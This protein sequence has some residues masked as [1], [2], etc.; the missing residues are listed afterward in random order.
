MTG[1]DVRAAPPARQVAAGDL[2]FDVREWGPADGRLV[3]A[4]HGFPQ[5]GRVWT[6]LGS[7]LAADGVRLVAPDIRGYSPGARPADV[8]AYRQSVVGDDVPALVAA[9]GADRADVV[10]HDWGAAQAWQAA[11]RHPGAVRS[12]VA[13]SVPHPLAVLDALADPDQRGRA[14]YIRWFRRTPDAAR[15][16]L[17]DDAAV[18]REFYADGAGVDVDAWVEPLRDVERLDA[19]LQWY[20][21][22][23]PDAVVGLGDVVCPTVHVWSDGDRALGRTGAEATARHVAGPYRFV[24]LPGGS[25]WIPEEAPDVV[26]REVRAQLAAVPA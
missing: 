24:E 2:V 12:L 7:A 25:H 5:D 11:A 9:L 8:A 14:E 15:Q 20:R 23:G 21:A 1:A 3:L 4:L 22:T 26:E 13:L 16:L 19:A 17:A 10:A 18:L 6:A